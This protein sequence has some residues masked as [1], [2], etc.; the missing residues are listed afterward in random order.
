[1]NLKEIYFHNKFNL[2]LLLTACF[3]SSI[4]LIY[5][6][7]SNL[8]FSHIVSVQCS[9]SFLETWSCTEE[10]TDW[11]M[12]KYCQ[13]RVQVL[14]PSS[15]VQYRGYYNPGCHHPLTHKITTK[16]S[17]LTQMYTSG[18]RVPWPS[19]TCHDLLWL[20]MTFHEQ[21]QYEFYLLYPI[22]C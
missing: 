11:A 9:S 3:F 6:F 22:P 8:Y 21:S 15:Q 5:V 19:L 17:S 20:S 4:L 18:A 14:N 10:N 16:N 7:A 13:V 2:Q 1:M 12:A